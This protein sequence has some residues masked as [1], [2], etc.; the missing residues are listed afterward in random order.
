M[1]FTMQFISIRK[2]FEP[3]S[4]VL[5]HDVFA[6]LSLLVAACRVS[7]SLGTLQPTAPSS[8]PPGTATGVAKRKDHGATAVA[9]FQLHARTAV[10]DCLL[11]FYAFVCREQA[12]GE[13]ALDIAGGRAAAPDIDNF[14]SFTT[15]CREQEHCSAAV[16]CA[17][18]HMLRLLQAAGDCPGLR[19][20]LKAAAE[21][22]SGVPAPLQRL[23]H[24]V[25]RHAP[26]I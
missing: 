14:A 13:A 16:A 5:H 20:T 2:R 17:V 18:A 11:R 25:R 4:P 3:S 22:Q 24:A 7:L 19:D 8:P 6:G 23:L 26:E 12:W 9:A 15:W 1:S 21:C 10:S